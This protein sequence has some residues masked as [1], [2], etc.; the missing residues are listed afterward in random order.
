MPPPASALP[1]VRSA[2]GARS[3]H[4]REARSGPPPPARSGRSRRARPGPPP[5]VRSGHPRR[6]AILSPAIL[7]IVSCRGCGGPR[8]PNLFLITIDSLR[9]DHVHG[10]G[11][12][13]DT[14]PV[15]DGLLREGTAWTGV[16]SAAPWT[17]P[18]MMSLMTGL[19][20]EVHHV[21]EDDRVLASPVR[22]LAQRFHDAGYATAAFVPEATLTAR[23]GF[24][25]GFDQFEERDF[26]WTTVTSPAQSSSVIAFIQKSLAEQDAHG[27]RG[28]F[29]VWVHLWDPHYNYNPS[30]PYDR[31]FPAG[32][33]PPPGSVYDMIALKGTK[34]P[35]SAAQIEYVVGQYDGEIALTDHYVGEM[36]DVL[37]GAGKLEATL[38]VVAG[39]HGEAFQEH[40]WLTHTNT[41]YEETVRVPVIARWPARIPAGRKIDRPRSL[42]DLTGSLADWAG[43]APLATQSRPLPLE[44][45]P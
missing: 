34:S 35:L 44:E 25:R 21:D 5:P 1:S 29:F 42:V 26:G 13:R 8:G 23:F 19:Y 15:L 43:L 45:P 6:A 31:R 33:P 9:T 27:G 14:T 17:T 24:S 30:P 7:A 18:S 22:T 11:Y 12:A 38:V 28:R 20:P 3:G 10:L 2:P 37:R 16:V 39:D 32:E 36:L 40:G 41:V 4:P